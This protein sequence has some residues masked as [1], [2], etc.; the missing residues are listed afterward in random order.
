MYDIKHEEVMEYIKGKIDSSEIFVV[1]WKEIWFTVE[2]TQG[3]TNSIR[4]IV[5]LHV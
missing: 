1:P 5:N 4:E 2:G 3:Y